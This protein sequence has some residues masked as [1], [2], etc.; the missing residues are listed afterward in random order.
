MGALFF[1]I[2][3]ENSFL[4]PFNGNGGF[5]G[6]FLENTFLF[7]LINFSQAISYYLLISIIIIFFLISIK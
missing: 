3:Y 7:T 1:T 5:V 2:Y 4:L 6:K